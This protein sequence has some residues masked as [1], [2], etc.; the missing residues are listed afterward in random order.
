MKRAITIII[1]LL[2]FSATKISAANVEITNISIESKTDYIYE[3]K[4]ATIDNLNIDCNLK[5]EDFEQNIIYKIT[6]KNNTGYDY[7]YYLSL[8]DSY[9]KYEIID[10]EQTINSKSTKN[11]FLK[12]SYNEE[13]DQSLYHEDTYNI[14]DKIELILTGPEV[15]GI[16]EEIL[17]G[18]KTGLFF[19]YGL[20]ILIITI[21]TI[22]Y[23]KTKRISL[24]KY[25]IIL[26]LLISPIIVLAKDNKIV[27]KMNFNIEIIKPK[28]AI[29]GTGGYVNSYFRYASPI[30]NVRR[31]ALSDSKKEGSQELQAEESE[32]P[33]YVWYESD[34]NTIYM[35]SEANRLYYNPDSSNL[36]GGMRSLEDIYLLKGNI[37]ENTSVMF[38]EV[39]YNVEN[40]NLDL[41]GFNVKNVK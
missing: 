19:N 8:N 5:F 9:I 29:L 31:I 12:V 21:G 4:N 22:L 24:F 30:E 11:V 32:Y 41:T 38:R 40:F 3:T 35:Y 16:I 14:Q 10:E 18:P 28:I 34:D 2:C 23:F 15:K 33:I 6:L 36:Y 1:L 17:N 7:N 26:L 13:I 27:I 20:T 37:L 39:G 25:N